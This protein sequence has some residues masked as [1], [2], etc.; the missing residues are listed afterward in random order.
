MAGILD[1]DVPIRPVGVAPINTGRVM[2]TEHAK[3]I[4]THGI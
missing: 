1:G 3:E 4:R 2:E